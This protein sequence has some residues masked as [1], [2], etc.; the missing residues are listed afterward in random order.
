MDMDRVM[1]GAWKWAW[2]LTCAIIIGIAMH[3][4]SVAYLECLFLPHFT[5]LDPGSRG[6]KGI[7][8]WIH[9]T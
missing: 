1:A 9:N 6:Q 8:S 3:R 5:T 7:G 2:T 4:D